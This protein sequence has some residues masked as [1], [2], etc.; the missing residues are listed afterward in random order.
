MN[1]TTDME[2]AKLWKQQWLSGVRHKEGINRQN[3]EDFKDSKTILHDT[4]LADTS[5]IAQIP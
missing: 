3:T 2:K 4:T 5:Y 1:P